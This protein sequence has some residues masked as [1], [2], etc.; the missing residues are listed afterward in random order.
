MQHAKHILVLARHT[1]EGTRENDNQQSR[2]RNCTLPFRRF[3]ATAAFTKALPNINMAPL[4]EHTLTCLVV[5]A[6]DSPEMWK[7]FYQTTRR[8]TNCGPT[9]GYYTYIR[10]ALTFCPDGECAAGLILTIHTYCC[11]SIRA[12]TWCV[13]KTKYGVATNLVV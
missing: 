10:S 4:N 2:G 1:A 8:R 5:Q 7:H 12:E 11:L 13:Q 9:A 3:G 6:T